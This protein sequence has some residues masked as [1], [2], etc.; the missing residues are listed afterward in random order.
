MRRRWAILPMLL[1]L[2]LDLANPLT[3]G[4]LSFV[5][6]QVESVDACPERGVQIDDR[7]LALVPGDRSPLQSPQ[8]SAL[9]Q[10][11]R[12][13]GFRPRPHAS[14]GGLAVPRSLPSSP[15]DD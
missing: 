13:I 4:L 8:A 12:S 9:D 5:A 6:G 1:Y 7:D 15:D 10:A 14:P 3:P 11:A 2:T